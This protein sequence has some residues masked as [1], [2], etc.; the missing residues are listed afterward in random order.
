MS[1][2]Y[3]IHIRGPRQDRSG[4]RKAKTEYD[5]YFLGFNKKCKI[6]S[7]NVWVKERD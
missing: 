5:S 6:V 4:D 7:G 2:Q 3:S 1:L